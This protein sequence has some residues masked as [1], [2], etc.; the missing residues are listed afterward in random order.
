MF[1]I[2][3]F[4]ESCRFS[5]VDKTN[6]SMLHLCVLKPNT[7]GK[8]LTPGKLMKLFYH[9]ALCKTHRLGAYFMETESHFCDFSIK[10]NLWVLI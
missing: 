5:P 1:K 3:H 7:C 8:V 2:N 6:F 9:I 4:I 10:Y